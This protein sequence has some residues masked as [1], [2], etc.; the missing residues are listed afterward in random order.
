MRRRMVV[1]HPYPVAGREG[2]RASD[3]AGVGRALLQRPDDLVGPDRREAGRLRGRRLA[4]AQFLGG[5]QSLLDQQGLKAVQPLLVVGVAEILHRPLL[6]SR[7]PP[8]VHGPLPP[9]AARPG[10]TAG[11]LPPPLPET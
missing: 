3:L 10:Q 9:A 5:D 8:L 7:G 6:L 1:A 11:A 2:R 4:A